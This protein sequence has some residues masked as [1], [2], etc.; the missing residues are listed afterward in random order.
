MFGV[1]ITNVPATISGNGN[2]NGALRAFGANVWSGQITLAGNSMDLE[3]AGGINAQT[4]GVT[5]ASGRGARR[6]RPDACCSTRIARSARM[7]DGA[8][9]SSPPVR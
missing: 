2:G 3:F 8:S 1:G 5:V 4:R 7:R 9:P 6:L